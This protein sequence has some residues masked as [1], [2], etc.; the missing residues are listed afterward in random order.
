MGS[1]KIPLVYMSIFPKT[2]LLFWHLG[3]CELWVAAPL[4][5]SA[6]VPGPSTLSSHRTHTPAVNLHLHLQ[7]RM[8]KSGSKGGGLW[9]TL[10]LNQP[11]GCP[12]RDGVTSVWPHFL[13]LTYYTFAQVIQALQHYEFCELYHFDVFSKWNLCVLSPGGKKRLDAQV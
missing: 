1:W 8:G 13:T 6:V 10:G 2:Q 5:L 4:H 7:F 11:W 9:Q 3:P 12:G